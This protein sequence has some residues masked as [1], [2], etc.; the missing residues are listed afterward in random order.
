MK[1]KVGDKVKTKKGHIGEIKA[2]QG[3]HFTIKFGNWDSGHSGGYG[4]NERGSKNFWNYSEREAERE[5]EI[6]RK[7]KP[8]DPTHLVVWEI[9]GCGDPCEFFTDEKKAKEFVKELSEKSDVKK[10]SII[11]VEIKSAQKVNVIKNVR[12][13]Q[14]K[15]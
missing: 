13:N 1:F 12:L 4:Y 15:I 14:Y 9:E 8:K 11:L 5:L 3:N 2:M 10:D 6:I 7:G